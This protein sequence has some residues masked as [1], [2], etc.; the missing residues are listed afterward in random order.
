MSSRRAW[1]VV[2]RRARAADRD[3]VLGF[4]TRTWDGWDYIPHAWDEW[5]DSADGVMLVAVPG[6]PA[7]GGPALDASG[8]VLPAGQAIAVARVAMLSAR[9]AWLEGIRVDPRVRGM[10]VATDLQV[11]ELR[12]AAA[13]GASFVR[14]ATGGS[15]EASHRLGARHD[16][17]P[18]VSYR[19]YRWTESGTDEERGDEPHGFDPDARRTATAARQALLRRLAEAGPEMGVPGGSDMPAWWARLAADTGFASAHGLYE[20]R[21][22]ALQELTAET[23]A[24]HV[25][26]GEVIVAPPGREG[27]GADEARDWA[28]AILPTEALPAEDVSVHLALLAGD[29]RAVLRLASEIRRLGGTPIRFRLPAAVVADDAAFAAAGFVAREWTLDI[30]GR[31][32]DAAHP[33]P[34]PD[35]PAA[36]VME[37]EPRPSP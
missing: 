23:F 10:D 20:H 4:A 15:N 8:E 16:F 24:R 1:P 27:E 9:E 11:A 13:Q 34:E 37:P 14:Y 25:A 35:D 7:G 22:W 30:L 31:P 28:L 32:L 2:V 29:G 6:E 19:T 36:L 3:A 5:L 18:L 33:P 26:R 12:W 21:A 17:E